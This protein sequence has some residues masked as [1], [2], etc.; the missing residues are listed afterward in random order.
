M[1][2]TSNLLVDWSGAGAL[3]CVAA[4]D[5][6]RD[7]ARHRRDTSCRGSRVSTADKMQRNDC[8]LMRA[9]VAPRFALP[10][11]QGEG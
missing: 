9:S 4:S 10:Q 1:K 3:A 5:I 11:V 8:M 6:Q 7:A 2:R